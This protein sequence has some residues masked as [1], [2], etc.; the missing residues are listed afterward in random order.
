MSTPKGVR[1]GGRQKGTP[2]KVNAAVSEK[3][4]RWKCDPFHVL[5]KIAMGDLPC[6]TCYGK[7]RTKFQSGSSDFPGE[8]ICQS[9]WGSRR[10][11]I[12]TA[13]RS[14]AAAELTEFVAAK[15][16]AVEVT[17]A[18]GG[19]LDMVLEVVFVEAGR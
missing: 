9:C 10:E 7:G 13:E 11:R 1:Y 17:G 18:D 14:R 6:G 16:K 3:L 5:A 12:T 2:N 15:R 19:P 4:A 8:R